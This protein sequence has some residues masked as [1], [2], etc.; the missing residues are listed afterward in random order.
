MTSA[1]PDGRVPMDVLLDE[2][3]EEF[4]AD[5]DAADAE[6]LAAI[7][8]LLAHPVEQGPGGG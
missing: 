2:K 1:L 4:L 3:D 6:A 8:A 5:W 7:Q